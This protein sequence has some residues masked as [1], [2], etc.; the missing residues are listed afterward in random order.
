M[1]REALADIYDT[2]GVPHDAD[3][4]SIRRGYREKVRTLRLDLAEDPEAANRLRELTHAYEVL[5]NPSSR[6]V[7]D[8]IAL[9]GSGAERLEPKAVENG[10]PSRELARIGDEELIAWVLGRERHQNGSPAAAVPRQDQLVRYVA[11][12]GFVVALVFLVA[13]LLHG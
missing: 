5:S 3:V 4:L 7:Y 2:L 9:R 11:N 10:E 13:L 12:V 6:V 1:P 8:R